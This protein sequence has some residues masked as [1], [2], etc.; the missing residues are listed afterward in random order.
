MNR[1]GLE[2]FMTGWN[3]KLVGYGASIGGVGLIAL[4]FWPIYRDIQDATAASVLLMLVLVVATKFGTGPAIAA[5]VLGAIYLNFFFVPPPFKLQLAGGGDLVALVTFLVVSIVVGQLS[6]R[7]QRK[8]A[9][10]QRLYDQLRDAFEQSSKLEAIK[11]SEQ[12]KSALLDAVTHD[13]RTPLTS[14][15]AAA[16]ALT[17]SQRNRTSL[18][19]FG[20]DAEREFLNMIVDQADRLNHFIEGMLELA[21]VQSGNFGDQ[22]STDSVEEIIG[23]ALARAD[24]LLANHQVKCIC[25]DDLLVSSVSPKAIAQVV[26]SLVENAT[27]HAPRGSEI[28]IVADR[29][30]TE[31]IKMAVE[32]DGPGIAPEYRQQ[33]FEKFFQLPVE[34]PAATSVS[35]GLGL[36][37]AIARGI[38]EAHGGKIWIEDKKSGVPGTR[39]VFTLKSS[40]YS[41]QPVASILEHVD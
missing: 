9:E 24:K 34:A 37:L 21:K 13:L 35:P 40:N 8:T 16:T 12:L 38:V 4:I 29:L 28:T 31:E 19:G 15:K 17:N 10:V 25:E 2:N 1:S 22:A 30:A 7:A 39:V 6:A 33:V 18:S 23:A 11:Q 26:F 27:R 20:P 36:G 3:R 5:S 14:I 41:R 32:D